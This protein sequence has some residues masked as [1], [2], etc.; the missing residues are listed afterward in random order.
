MLLNKEN[1]PK[2]KCM[3]VRVSEWLLIHKIKLTNQVPIL[4]VIYLALIPKGKTYI[5]FFSY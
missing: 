4:F 2:Q 5:H 1:K 3:E